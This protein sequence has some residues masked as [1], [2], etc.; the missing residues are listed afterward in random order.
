ME[1]ERILQQLAEL[2]NGEKDRWDA[3]REVFAKYGLERLC[4]EHQLRRNDIGTKPFFTEWN[5]GDLRSIFTEL[6]E[7]NYECWEMTA[8]ILREMKLR[9]RPS[10]LVG[11]IAS[12]IEHFHQI[13]ARVIAENPHWEHEAFFNVCIDKAVMYVCR[14]GQSFDE[15]DYQCSCEHQCRLCGRFVVPCSTC[16]SQKN[17]CEKCFRLCECSQADYEEYEDVMSE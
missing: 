2:L 1:E 4:A 14:C 3:S 17:P 11:N 13:S 9:C 10:T 7:T 16:E 6:F 12:N 15:N 8:K 5:I